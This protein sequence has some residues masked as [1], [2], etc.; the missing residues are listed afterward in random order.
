MFKKNTEYCIKETFGPFDLMK[1][2]TKQDKFG[3][4]I[5]VTLKGKTNFK[6]LR[7]GTLTLCLK[8]YII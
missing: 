1:W 4:P 8:V 7:G 5:G 3:L 6:T 2:V